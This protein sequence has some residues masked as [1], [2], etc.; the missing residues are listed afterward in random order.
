MSL[1]ALHMFVD[2]SA[3]KHFSQLLEK[4]LNELAEVKL[5][6]QAINAES[7]L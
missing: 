7:F 2:V 1:S 4:L 6:E 3:S 5:T